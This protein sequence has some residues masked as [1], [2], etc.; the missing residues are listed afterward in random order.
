MSRP[1]NVCRLPHC[2]PR[3]ALRPEPRRAGPTPP[4]R[5]SETHLRKRNRGGD[6]SSLNAATF[7]SARLD[8]PSRQSGDRSRASPIASTRWQII[9]RS[10]PALNASRIVSAQTVFIVDRAHVEIVGHDQPLEPQIVAQQIASRCAATRT[11][12]A[13]PRRSDGYQ[14]WQ[15]I[16]L[17]TRFANCRKTASSSRLEFLARCARSA[18]DRGARRPPPRSSRGN[19]SRSSRSPPLASASLKAPAS[20]T[21]CSTVCP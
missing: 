5:S 15:I 2:V 16:M 21:T 4:H 10:L 3:R 11:P 17:S 9:A 1:A 14:P 19:V 20:R 18:A 8:L 7:C 12:A 13:S 6:I